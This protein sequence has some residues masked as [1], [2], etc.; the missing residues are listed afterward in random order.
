MRGRR[1]LGA[2]LLALVVAGSCGVAVP[3]DEVEE[4]PL[5]S[6]QIR[7]EVG[8]LR[9]P[10]RTEEGGLLF[11]RRS[12][13][14]LR[15]LLER[16]ASPDARAELILG[17]ATRLALGGPTADEERA[18]LR[19]ALPEGL[20]V[21][22][23]R[24]ALPKGGFFVTLPDA[25]R[26]SFD[27]EKAQLLSEAFLGLSRNAPEVLDHVLEVRFDPGEPHMPIGRALP[28][29]EPV[30]PKPG[31]EEGRLEAT[32][33]P[34]AGGQGQPAGYLSG[35]SVF[36]N[37]GHGWYYNGT[38]GRWATQRGNTNYIIEDLS[39]AEAVNTYLT[40]YLWN[41]GAGVYTCRERDMNP[42]MVVVDNG[43]GGYSETGTWAT[44]TNSSAYGGSYRRAVTSA[45]E[46]ASAT[47]VP[48][49]PANGY[50][51]VT[52]WY[53]GTSVNANDAEVTVTHTG[54]STVVTLNQERDGSTFK[55]LGLYYFRAG[56]NPANGSVKIS[57]R[58]AE[59]GNYVVADAVRLGGG[60]GAETPFGEPFASGWPRFEE[61]GPYYANF[62]GCPYAT[63]GESTVN[64]MPRY[65]AW[66]NE[67]WEDSVFVSWHSNAFDGTGR[68][69]SSFAYASGGW[70][71]PFNG[72]EGGLELR[73]FVHAELIADLR[74]GYDASWPNQ[75]LHTNWYGEINPSNNPEMPGALFEMAYHDN[76]TDALH[77]KNPIFRQIVA[78]AVYQG[79]VKY[80][81]DRDGDA[82]YTLL[83]EPPTALRVQN[84]G[85]GRVILNWSAPPASAHSGLYGD[86]ATGY[87]VYRSADG[88]GFDDGVALG[89][90]GTT[91]FTDASVVPGTTTFYRVSATNAGG[92]SFPTET[93]AVRAS[94]TTAPVLVVSGFDRLHY[95]QVVVTDDP[96]DTDALHRSFVDRMNSYRYAV[97]FGRAIDAYGA[98]FDSC[99]NEG[100][101]SG[102]VNLSAYD[103]VLWIS[104]EESTAD[105]TFDATE[106]S[107]LQAYLEGGGK[108]FVSGSEIGWDLD[109][110]GN[111]AAFFNGSLRADYAGDDAGTY[112]VT[113]SS[114]GVFAGNA[115]LT[116]DDGSHG[117]YDC[118]YPDQILPLSGAV[119]CLAYAGGGG[120]NAGI[121]YDGGA[122]RVVTF[123]FPFESIVEEVGRNETMADILNF[124]GVLPDAG[125]LV[126]PAAIGD[127]V[128]WNPAL[129]RWEWQAVTT[130]RLGNPE[131]TLHYQ[132]WRS[133]SPESLGDLLATLTESRYPD[134]AAPTSG[135]WFYTVRGADA[136]GNLDGAETD[137]I[138]D[139]P[140][141]A[142][143]GSWNTGTT[144]P[145][146]YGD[147]YRWVYTG[148][149]GSVTA[150][151]TF[152]CRE[153]GDYALKVFYPQGTNRS[154]QSRF[155]ASHAT[156]STLFL[157]NQQVGGGTWNEL[158]TVWLE[159]GQ[160]YSVVLDD[161]E[162]AGKVVIADAV[163]WV[164]P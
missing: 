163:R 60:T 62:M 149:S 57:N 43:G 55:D 140:R 108:L 122:T 138:R 89:G 36:V 134:A 65:C 45:S 66:E 128:R 30:G 77:L 6:S 68:G 63:C 50:Y 92:E 56:S 123:G 90:A 151:W 100:V 107:L 80:F 150:T 28:V 164:K 79:I 29:P 148:G 162:P 74:A 145:G 95:L 88:F 38:L 101:I 157:V 47:F 35:K 129:G 130:D 2:W 125:D 1:T 19:P 9:V 155:T 46:T 3:A 144:A 24:A 8:V 117:E 119:A 33:Q 133:T 52:L 159:P 96:Y 109:Y 121:Q 37:P 22:A 23:V 32:G 83:P 13:P 42:N 105:K 94:Y 20:A 135:C 126:A 104:G 142:L 51:R 141:A 18:G 16:E 31:E 132:V 158:G 111:G 156:G 25:W 118:N 58:S 78:R 70:D 136:A 110:S 72:V 127:T 54:G 81:A 114:G 161:A 160:T 86:P 39:N 97:R 17:T 87:R 11:V 49:V 91:T 34:P 124:F 7:A 27:E 102:A 15:S 137:A 59:S 26:G 106:Q 67:S 53:Y 146:H 71:Y 154:D 40:H 41:A 12:A 143:Q 82:S 4:L 152:A 115:A 103:A 153:R 48:A 21:D 76:A 44:V 5:E 113:A 139:N 120:G 147:D 73:N 64:A 85:A 69:T 99:G 112:S 14:D 98:A 75:G 131:P 116:F 10:L 84:D 61:A 93:L